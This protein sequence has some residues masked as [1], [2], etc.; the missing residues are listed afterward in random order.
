M[1]TPA[2]HP[3]SFTHRALLGRRVRLLAL[4][5]VAASTVFPVSGLGV[6]LCP[7][8]LATGLPCPG[9]GLSRGVAAI[10]QGDFA[11]AAG[12]NPFSLLAW[13]VL[14]VL[15]VLA[16]APERL[17]R[18]LEARLDVHGPVLTRA[19]HVVLAALLG[20]GLLRLAWLLA[21]GESFP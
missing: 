1:T 17:V 18:R 21:T 12:L 7:M 16:L 15:A 6:D 5:V 13:P 3:Q 10:S 11:A 8:H 2:A 4:A 19:F 9:C 20:F 14:V